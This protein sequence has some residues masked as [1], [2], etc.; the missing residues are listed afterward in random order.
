MNTYDALTLAIS[1][2]NRVRP[3]A[4]DYDEVQDAL[5]TLRLLREILQEQA[6]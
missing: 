6:A 5:D 2:L 3:T 4:A 1:R